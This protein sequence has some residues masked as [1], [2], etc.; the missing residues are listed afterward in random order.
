MGTT[1]KETKIIG[2]MDTIIMETMEIIM[3]IVIMETAMEATMAITV[4]K[5]MDNHMELMDIVDIADIRITIL[6]NRI[7]LHLHTLVAVEECQAMALIDRHPMTIMKR[8]AEKTTFK[9]FEI[10]IV[11]HYTNIIAMT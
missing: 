7:L 10:S 3:E 11:K 2:I 8:Y 9:V 6:P 5:T 1:A 4:I